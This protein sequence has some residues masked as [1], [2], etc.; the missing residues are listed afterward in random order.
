MKRVAYHDEVQ[1]VDKPARA[2]RRS[3]E[4]LKSTIAETAALDKESRAGTLRQLF[5]QCQNVGQ[6]RANIFDWMKTALNAQQ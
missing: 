4:R 3:G 2:P 1:A 6:K 5:A